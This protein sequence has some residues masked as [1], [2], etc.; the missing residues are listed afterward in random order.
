MGARDGSGDGFGNGLGGGA[1]GGG[2]GDGAGDG[3]GDE[4]LTH[5][6]SGP[7]SRKVFREQRGKLVVKRTS[8]ATFFHPILPIMTAWSV[9]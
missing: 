3:L 1:G 8:Y 4:S 6:E 5:R 7:T 2:S 9:L